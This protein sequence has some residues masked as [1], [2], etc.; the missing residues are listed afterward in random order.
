MYGAD[1][2]LTK[3]ATNANDSHVTNYYQYN[4]WRYL[5]K[6]NSRETKT[7]KYF[8]NMQK[9]SQRRFENLLELLCLKFVKLLIY[10][11]FTLFIDEIFSF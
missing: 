5:N 7:R 6:K 8:P 3:L 11:S 1:N 4:E 10:K 2:I 9:G